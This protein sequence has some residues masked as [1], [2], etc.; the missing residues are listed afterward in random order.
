[1][2]FKIF[3]TCSGITDLH[4]IYDTGHNQISERKYNLFSDFF[5]KFS[6]GIQMLSALGRVYSSF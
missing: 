1:M 6:F 5:R 2:L 3:C 4:R